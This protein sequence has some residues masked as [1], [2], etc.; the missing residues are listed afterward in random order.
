MSAPAA[1]G[2][3]LPFVRS[4]LAAL[5]AV[6]ALILSL[7]LL[8]LI[9]LAG[10]WTEPARATGSPVD[11]AALD[12]WM[13]RAVSDSPLVGLG[14]VF[15]AE[16][17]RQGLDPRAL[18]AIARHE[19]VLGTAGSGAGIHNAFGWGPG[20]RFASWEAN[21]ATVAGGL[22]S[23][24]VG[25]GRA[26]LAAIQP[27]WAPVGATN[28]PTDLNSAWLEAVGRYYSDLGG[29]P[30]RPITL[31]AQGGGLGGATIGPAGLATP[32][33]GVG[34]LGGRPGEG[35][36]DY[37]AWPNNWQSDRAVDISL[38]FGS[39]LFAIGAGTVVRVGGNPASFSG[40]FGG[41]QLTVVS[42]DD[43]YYYAHLSGLVV[44][45][46]ERVGLGQLI[47]FSGSANGSD[48]L[49]L[50]VMRRDPVALIGLG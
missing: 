4:G 7:P 3:A 1:A 30:A 42:A 25:R 19:S 44:R 28:D 33:G 8:A 38:P 47:G 48:H 29:D 50:G 45:E 6:V 2:A 9:A 26:T 21:I 5:A 37:G 32:T 20:I 39:P 41:A 13:E 18:V 24:Y 17:V 15:V 22:A 12:E 43:A 34:A 40:R 46:G 23:N 14:H 16:G 31:E 35:T 10:G 36:H 27:I 11:A 49:H